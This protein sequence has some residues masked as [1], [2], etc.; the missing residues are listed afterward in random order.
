MAIIKDKFSGDRSSPHG[1]PRPVLIAWGHAPEQRTCRQFLL[2]SVSAADQSERTG[3]DVPR[4]ASALLDF[5]GDSRV[6]ARFIYRF[7]LTLAAENPP[8]AH[9]FEQ[10]ALPVGTENPMG[11]LPCLGDHAGRAPGVGIDAWPDGLEIPRAILL[12]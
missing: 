9:A 12:E 8:F 10:V 7:E 3:A 6:V 1:R 4:R 2:R 11:L 5:R